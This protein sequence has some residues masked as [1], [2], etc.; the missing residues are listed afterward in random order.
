[1]PSYPNGYIKGYPDTTVSDASFID[2]S[3][4][5]KYTA[6]TLFSDGWRYSGVDDIVH[7]SLYGLSSGHLQI[8]VE[9]HDIKFRHGHDTDTIRISNRILGDTR[10]TK[11]S[12]LLSQD[13]KG[14]IAYYNGSVW[15]KRG[16]LTDISSISTIGSDISS[17]VT[18]PNSPSNN[19]IYIFNAGATGLSDYE[20]SEGNGLTVSSKGD[21]AQHDGTNWIKK[22]NLS[23]IKYI[24]EVGSS[25]VSIRVSNGFPTNY[26]NEDIHIFNADVSGLTNYRA[27]DSEVNGYIHAFSSNVTNVSLRS[28][29]ENQINRAKKSRGIVVSVGTRNIVGEEASADVLVALSYGLDLPY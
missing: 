16:S 23:D 9:G 19:D 11:S 24:T 25:S 18:F 6:V 27:N 14:G 4:I 1:M 22:G 15:I 21:I 29:I 2:K 13:I 26:G 10:T 28:N 17:G 7:G 12:V 5:R 8:C 20:D 3:D